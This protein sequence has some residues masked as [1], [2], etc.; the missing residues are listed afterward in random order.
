M[1]IG[2]NSIPEVTKDIKEIKLILFEYIVTS[3]TNLRPLSIMELYTDTYYIQRIQKGDTACF[4]CLLDKYSRPVHSLILKVVQNREDAEELAQ[5][6]FMKVFRNL[7]KFKGESSFSTWIYR[8]AYNTAISATRKKKYEFLAVEETQLTNISEEEVELAMGRCSSS[9]QIERLEKALL[10]LPP[11]ERAIIL[12]FHIEQKTIEDI[13]TIT[14]LSYSNVKTRLHRIRK[15]LFVL[16]NEK[17]R[18]EY[19]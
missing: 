13:T 1:L 2:R 10:L 17:E 6:V 5:D 14:G 9:G 7:G 12:L 8:I 16:L 3:Q 11:D 19:E 15:K 4:A 18:E